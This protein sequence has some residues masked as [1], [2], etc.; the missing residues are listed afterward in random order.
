MSRR[1]LLVAQP[2]GL[3]GRE[4]APV[5]VIVIAALPAAALPAALPAA[6]AAGAA[7]LAPAPV[8]P[9]VPDVPATL[10]EIFFPVA[11]LYAY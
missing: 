10:Q 8:V 5:P 7:T 11:T 2:S 1:G 9:Q 6:L 4:V 3:A